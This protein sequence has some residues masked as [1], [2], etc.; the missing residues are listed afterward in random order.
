MTLIDVDIEKYFEEK[1][2]VYFKAGSKNVS[3]GWIGI[4]CPFCDDQSNHCGINL[5]A[6]NFFCFVC[7]E[8]GNLI[9]LLKQIETGIT[10]QGIKNILAEYLGEAFNRDYSKGTVLGPRSKSII[11]KE[12][13]KDN[14]DQVLNIAD[15]RFLAKEGFTDF[16]FL[17]KKYGII[18]SK[19]SGKYAYRIIVPIYYY[20]EAVSFVGIDIT[21]K[22]EIK[23]KNA[24]PEE[25]KIPAKE[26]LYNYDNV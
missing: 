14:K 26:L 16:R 21:G 8:K 13:G 20:R 5:K 9:K 3:K 2:V 19:I 25:E 11:P 1:G 22:Q 24:S 23:Y 12:Y 7:G 18:G 17:K 6:K 4:Q 15:K 10:W